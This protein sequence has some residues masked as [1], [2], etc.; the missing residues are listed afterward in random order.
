[1]ANAEQ[2]QPPFSD[3]EAR[4]RTHLYLDRRLDEQLH[5]YRQ[6][7]A[8]FNYNSNALLV[9]SALI[10]GVSTVMSV[11]SLSADHPVAMLMT[12]ILPA[13]ATALASFRAVYQWERQKALYDDTILELRRAR[14]ELPDLDHINHEQY[15]TS[16]PT[17]VKQSE[18]V[19]QGEASQWGQLRAM[20]PRTADDLPTVEPQDLRSPTTPPDDEAPES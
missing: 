4:L 16:F 17:L 1:M 20:M 7:I 13:I 3:R 9:L 18:E 10:M 11:I 6:R 14:S 19:F 12:A 15:N 5:F 8:E 2:Q